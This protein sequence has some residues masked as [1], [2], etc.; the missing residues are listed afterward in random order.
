LA[1]PHGSHLEKLENLESMRRY[2]AKHAESWYKYVN[3]TRGRRLVNGNLFLVTG[4]E[5]AESWGMAFFQDAPGFQLGFRPTADAANRYKYRWHGTH[6]RRKH[7]D[8]PPV[9]GTPL[10]Q[11]TFLHAFAISVREGM[12]GKLFGAAICQPVDSSTFRETSGHGFV[13]YGS[14]GSSF[15]LSFFFGSG[16][17][18][19][20]GKQYSGEVPAPGDGLLYDASPIP[21][22]RK[23]NIHLYRIDLFQVHSPIANNPRAHPPRGISYL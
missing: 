10:N 22:V 21:N 12:W 13:P 4:W 23:G 18:T 16:A 19:R 6:C 1:L 20:G 5:K 9:D 17:L 15:G 11:T 14:Q 8:P 2:A 3:E 7:A